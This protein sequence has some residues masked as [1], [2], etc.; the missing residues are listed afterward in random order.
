LSW[1]ISN[2]ILLFKIWHNL[3]FA[4]GE[5]SR[6]CTVI[7]LLIYTETASLGDNCERLFSWD[8]NSPSYMQSADL[9]GKVG[10][11]ELKAVN[12]QETDVLNNFNCCRVTPVGRWCW[13]ET[14]SGSRSESFRL[15]TNAESLATRVS[16]PGWQNTLTGYKKMLFEWRERNY[17]CECC[18]IIHK[19]QPK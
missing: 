14:T 15:E 2:F 11:V 17:M 5:P 4:T 9:C 3:D 1:K 16:I 7:I 19:C 18:N 8:E 13:S 6:F 12:C 10:R